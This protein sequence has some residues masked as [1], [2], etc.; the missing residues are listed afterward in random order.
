MLVSTLKIYLIITAVT[1]LVTSSPHTIQFHQRQTATVLVHDNTKN[2]VR[3]G[4]IRQKSQKDNRQLQSGTGVGQISHFRLVN[5]TSNN[6]GQP[7]IDPIINGT[8][9]NLY[10]YPSNQK[11]S[12]EAMVSTATG[13]IGSVLMQNVDGKKRYDYP[14]YSM[15]GD[16]KGTF[17]ACTQLN[18][19]GNYTVTATPYSELKATGIAG[20]PYAISFSVVNEPPAWI[21]VNPNATITLRHEACF[22]MV[23]RKAYV[24]AGRAKRNVD[25]YD[26]IARTWSLGAMP[27]IQ[28]HHTQCVVADNKIWIVSSWTGGYPMETNTQ[29][30]YVRKFAPLLDYCM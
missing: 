25:I 15:C 12:I 16:A 26:P 3:K 6:Q 9:I 22:V 1:T 13:P 14:R 7:I 5:A 18:V 23:G 20:K 10:N 21:V 28:I 24:L 19:V 29:F 30:I 2:A 17:S 4:N 27:P 11:I 8:K